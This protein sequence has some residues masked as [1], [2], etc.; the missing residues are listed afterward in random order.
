MVDTIYQ[1]SRLTDSKEKKKNI[2]HPLIHIHGDLIPRPHIEIHKPSV[3]DVGAAL[4]PFG[5]T[6][7]VAESAPGGRNGQHGDVA[8]PGGVVFRVTHGGVL[9]FELAHD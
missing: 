9:F 6:A 1:S 7:R 3:V 5:Q 8:V 4:E 2:P